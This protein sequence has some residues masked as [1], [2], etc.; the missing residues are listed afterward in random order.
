LIGLYI[1][2]TAARDTSFRP[3]VGAYTGRTI[4]VLLRFT[5]YH[6]SRSTDNLLRESIATKCP[7]IY[8]ANERHPISQ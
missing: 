4:G 3:L 8:R 5:I 6:S 1:T 7:K 2:S